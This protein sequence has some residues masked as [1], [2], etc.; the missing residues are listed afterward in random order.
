[1]YLL[2]YLLI[3]F[4]KKRVLLLN[5]TKEKDVILKGRVNL[6]EKTKKFMKYLKVN[7]YIKHFYNDTENGY[8]RQIKLNK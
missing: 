3:E 8:N 7:L 4:K 2:K 6:D 1:M 5:K